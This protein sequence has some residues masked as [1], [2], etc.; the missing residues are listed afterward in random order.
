MPEK[1]LKDAKGKIIG[2]VW[3]Y[4]KKEYADKLV[5]AGVVV[6]ACILTGVAYWKY[7]KG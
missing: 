6:V 2:L 3:E 1:Y 7:N 4:K 5:V